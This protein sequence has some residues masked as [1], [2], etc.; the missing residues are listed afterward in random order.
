MRGEHWGTVNGILGK[1]G[2]SPH[3]RGTLRCLWAGSGAIG[4]IPACA[5]N[6]LRLPRSGRP[7]GDHPRMR[8]EH[9]TPRDK[10]GEPLGSSPHARG[11]RGRRIP[12]RPFIGIIPAC[13]G[14]TIPCYRFADRNRDHPRMRGEH[15]FLDTIPSHERGSSPH[16]R[17]TLGDIRHSLART[18]IIPACAGNT[19]QGAG[20]VSVR[21]DHPRMRGEHCRGLAHPL[22]GKGSS[23][24]ARGTP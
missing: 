11:T 10:A 19:G 23:P 5:G 9:V 22:G 2:S 20:D 8:G 17:G 13:A 6:T 24:H 4:I 21:G 18:G 1:V 16:A 3:A 15:P 7:R 12:I 14:N